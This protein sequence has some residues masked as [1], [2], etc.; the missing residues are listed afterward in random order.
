MKLKSKPWRNQEI[1]S[2]MRITD[3]LLYKYS[4]LKDKRS[5]HDRLIHNEF[6]HI[7][8]DS[9]KMKRESK[10]NY[11]NNYFEANKSKMSSIWKGIRSIVNLNNSSKKKGEKCE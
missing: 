2:H 8:N 11:Y 5:E 10:I 3:K 9:I 1:R 6:K 4:K 7:R